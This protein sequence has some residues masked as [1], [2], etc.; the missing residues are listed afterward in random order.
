[1][2]PQ[3][4]PLVDILNSNQN[5]TKACLN[6]ISIGDFSKQYGGKG[7]SMQW[8]MGHMIVSRYFLGIMLG[9]KIEPLWQDKF[10]RGVKFSP[11]IVYAPLNEMIA[12]WD[13]ISESLMGHIKEMGEDE[14]APKVEFEFPIE[15]KTLLGGLSFM[16]LHDAYHVGQL[17]YLRKNLGYKSL[18]G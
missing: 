15:N 5:L 6:E 11:E 10:G 13:E 9:M 12:K 18:A 1:M 7:N 17:A 16:A 14:L 8:I 2:L 3:I 4:K